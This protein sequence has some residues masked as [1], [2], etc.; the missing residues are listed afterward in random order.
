MK[1]EEMIKIINSE[2]ELFLPRIGRGTQQNL[3][4]SHY[5]SL[6]RHDL[7][8]DNPEGPDVI[9]KKCYEEISKINSN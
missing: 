1:K 5:N 6:R 2:L 8:K 3:L 9:L 7:A 4:R